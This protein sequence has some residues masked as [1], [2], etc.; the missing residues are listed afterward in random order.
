LEGLNKADQIKKLKKGGL[1]DEDIKKL[2][3]EKDRIEA[4]M[5]LKND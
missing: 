4:I 3:Y 5:K 1:S 2:K